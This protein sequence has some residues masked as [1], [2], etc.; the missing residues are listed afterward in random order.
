MNGVGP[1]L[2]D[3]IDFAI[4]SFKLNLGDEKAPKFKHSFDLINY[5]PWKGG[6]G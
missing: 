4:I 2:K 6:S 5:S 1:D 3:T